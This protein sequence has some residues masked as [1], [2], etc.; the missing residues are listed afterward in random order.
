MPS[1]IASAV[2]KV[3]CLDTD[4]SGRF[5]DFVI[6]LARCQNV[7]NHQIS[8]VQLRMIA[9]ILRNLN[10]DEASRSQLIY[11]ASIRFSYT[12]ILHWCPHCGHRCMLEPSQATWI[13]TSPSYLSCPRATI[14]N[15]GT[16][17]STLGDG[18]RG[19]AQYLPIVRQT[20]LGT[21]YAVLP[22]FGLIAGVCDS[23]IYIEALRDIWCV[24]CCNFEHTTLILRVSD[25]NPSQSRMPDLPKIHQEP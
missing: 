4:T 6:V 8:T 10:M 2:L 15:L 3:V 18:P 23:Y 20:E 11:M 12:S 5:S 22:R 13:V 7:T 17:R 25:V 19:P 16:H 1:A 9:I 14:A 21:C 24:S